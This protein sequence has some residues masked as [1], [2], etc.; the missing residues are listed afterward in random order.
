MKCHKRSHSGGRQGIRKRKLTPAPDSTSRSRSRSRFEI[1]TIIIQPHNVSRKIK[2]KRL[3]REVPNRLQPRTIYV[4]LSKDGVVQ[5]SSH[6]FNLMD[7]RLKFIRK[8][9]HSDTIIMLDQF[10]VT[11]KRFTHMKRFYLKYKPWNN[12][13]IH[14]LLQGFVLLESFKSTELMYFQRYVEEVALCVVIE[15]GDGYYMDYQCD[16]FENLEEKVEAIT[17]ATEIIYGT[18]SSRDIERV[19]EQ[20]RKTPDSRELD[21]ITLMSLLL[22]CCGKNFLEEITPIALVG[23]YIMYNI[24]HTL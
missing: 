20:E 6:F 19:I 13:A 12:I 8:N 2:L 11:S 23:L 18:K 22:S 24:H 4:V 1:P 9:V 10:I 17:S 5:I 7:S 15:V 21:F 16:V 14:T 3:L